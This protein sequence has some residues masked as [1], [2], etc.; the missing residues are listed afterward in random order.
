MNRMQVPEWKVGFLKKG[1]QAI[2]Y[3]GTG[4]L[5]LLKRE[6][7]R[8]DNRP[9]ISKSYT[10]HYSERNL[11]YKAFFGMLYKTIRKATW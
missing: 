2:K 4:C 6:C 11:Y 10:N 5:D 3:G 7:V 9:R 8:T 1:C